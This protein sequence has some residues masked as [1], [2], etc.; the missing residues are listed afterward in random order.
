MVYRYISRPYTD[1]SLL[2]FYLTLSVLFFFLFFLLLLVTISIT[3]DDVHI[4]HSPFRVRIL[5][6]IMSSNT[7]TLSSSYSK[8][9]HIYIYIHK[10]ITATFQITSNFPFLLF[11]LTFVFFL[12]ASCCCYWCLFDRYCCSRSNYILSCLSC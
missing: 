5:P 9:T 3:L 12:C 1:Y 2:H 4:Q 6:T 11:L 8:Y 10:H 7:T